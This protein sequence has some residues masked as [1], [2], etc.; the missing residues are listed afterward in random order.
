MSWT[1]GGHVPTC[2]LRAKKPLRRLAIE[3]LDYTLSVAVGTYLTTLDT[4]AKEAR[5]DVLV[6][7][8]YVTSLHIGS[9]FRHVRIVEQAKEAKAV[10]DIKC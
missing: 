9:I 6:M 5:P 7:C 8:I 2:I 1:S 4:T 3:F 10:P